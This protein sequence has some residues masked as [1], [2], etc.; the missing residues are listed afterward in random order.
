M[1]AEVA[2]GDIAYT[3]RKWIAFILNQMILNCVKYCGEELMFTIR[4]E[5]G[6][7]GIY[8]IVEDNGVGIRA[9][10]I[11][12]I[13][14][15][16]F[17]GSNGRDHE[18]ATGMGLYLCRKLCDKLGIRLRAESEYGQGTRM[19]VEFPVSDYICRE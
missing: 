2:C 6:D 11:S 9:E 19:I 1:C 8:L 14:E 17:T 5:K 12:R 16:G 18:R 3:D 13:F 15:K 4:T 7:Q 10:E